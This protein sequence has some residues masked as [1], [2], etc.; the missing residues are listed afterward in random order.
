MVNDVCTGI[1]A[2]LEKS[3]DNPIVYFDSLPQGFKAPCFFI[4][5]V[6]SRLEPKLWNRYELVMDFDVIYYP[7]NPDEDNAIELHDVA[8][9]LLFQLEYI[10]VL[11]NLLRGIDTHFEVQDNVL[12]FFITYKVMI[13]KELVKSPLMQQLIQNYKIKG[14][15]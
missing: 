8:Y 11:K 9:K 3:F 2:E 14:V 5:L 13:F 7:H 4:N 10:T 15:E 12:H 1:A 6:D